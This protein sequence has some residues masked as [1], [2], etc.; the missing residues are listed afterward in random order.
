MKL[1]HFAS[2]IVLGSCGLVA[3]G[4]SRDVEVKGDVA[5]NDGVVGDEAIRLE[6]YEPR[7]AAE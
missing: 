7:A 5:A 3:C 4:S 2:L 1:S 6:F